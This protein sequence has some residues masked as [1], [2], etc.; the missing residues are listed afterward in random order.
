[1]NIRPQSAELH[2]SFQVATEKDWIVDSKQIIIE[3]YT[4][5]MHIVMMRFQY[6]NIYLL[7]ATESYFNGIKSFVEWKIRGSKLTKCWHENEIE[8]DQIN[9]WRYK[10]HNLF[11]VQPNCIDVSSK[12]HLVLKSIRT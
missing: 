10:L 6:A 5:L 11:N 12:G 2:E 8:R 1:M 4:K 7:A 3:D 9:L